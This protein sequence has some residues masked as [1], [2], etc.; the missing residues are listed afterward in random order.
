MVEAKIGLEIH[1]Q[2]N[3]K[4]KLFCGCPNKFS[5]EPNTLTCETCLGHPGSKP[6]FNKEALTKALKAALALKCKINQK[7]MFSRKTYFYPD[8][9]NNFQITQYEWPLAV[10]GK[11]Q[12][13][14]ITRMHIEEDPG[15]LVR[16]DNFVLIDYNRSGTPLIETVTAPDFKNSNDAKQF[17]IDFI[18]M[19]E[20]LDIYYRTSEATLRCDVNVSINNG[21][22]VEVKNVY[23]INEV[24]KVIDYE[25]ERQQHE[26][27]VQE[28][29]GWNEAEKITYSMRLKESEDDYGYITEPNLPVFE[30]DTEMIKKIKLPELA[31]EKAVRYVKSFKL[32]KEDSEVIASDSRLALIFEK[33]A[34]KIDPDFSAKFLRRELLKS[35]NESGKTLSELDIDE[36]QVIALI[37]LFSQ[38][39]VTDKVAR[40]LMER[41]LKE[42]FDVKEFVNKNNL[43]AVSEESGLKAFCEEA[44]KENPK[45]VEDYKNGKLEALNFLL[46]QVMRKSKGRASPEI[47]KKIIN[48]I[49]KA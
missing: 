38:K 26:K 18:N 22:R 9:P 24:K 27:A 6:Y 25:I 41:L 30:I 23:G 17:L 10:N 47:C 39:K 1:C 4:T 48:E 21:T 49:I 35:L 42:K 5:N 45:V 43:T 46:G 44:V 36:T 14:N 8:L 13:I 31:H 7:M 28:T 15:R 19:L 29:R 33:A 20:Y 11:F 3:T 37:E 2:L 16:K 32:A 34:K 12:G 40:Q